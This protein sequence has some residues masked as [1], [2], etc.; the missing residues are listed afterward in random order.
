V[1]LGPAFSLLT[2]HR[3]PGELLIASETPAGITLR[4]SENQQQTILRS[5][6]EQLSSTDLSLMPEGFAKKLTPPDFA[7]LIALLKAGP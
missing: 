4:R 3:S 6:V 7:D 2:D 1:P 5:D